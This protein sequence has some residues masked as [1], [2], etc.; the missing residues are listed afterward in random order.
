MSDTEDTIAAT[1][2][3]LAAERR[4]LRELGERADAL[5]RQSDPPAPP[6]DHANEGGMV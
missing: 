5:E 2:R 1:E 4:R 6:I 3:A